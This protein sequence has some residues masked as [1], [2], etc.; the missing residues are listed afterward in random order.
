MMLPAEKNFKSGWLIR[1]EAE[2]DWEHGERPEQRTVEENLSNG[3]V[4]I[5][6]PAGV[7]SH[8]VSVDIKKFM[9]RSKAGHS[10]TLDPDVTGVLPVGIDNAT[11]VLQALKHAGKEYKGTMNLSEEF[12]R[13][14]IEEV[15]EDFIGTVKQTP[16]EI[17][18][19]K[20]EE[21]EREVYGIEIIKVEGGKVDFVIECERGFYVRV[22]C[23]QFGEKL[24]CDGELDSLRRTKVGLF[25][26]DQCVKPE[27]LREQFQLYSDGKDHRLDQYVRPVEAGVK[28][29][30]KVLLKDTAVSP[31]CH[32]ADLGTM[33][34]SKLQ[35][36]IE[37]GETV[38]LLT[39]KGELVAIG[40]ALMES[41]EMLEGKDTAVELQRVFLDKDVYPR[42][43]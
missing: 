28:H 15:A 11:K 20:R 39:L 18:A 24:G 4:L 36:D 37:K 33:G 16:P 13:E 9:K 7:K 5:D 32:G 6:K 17:S 14:K 38:A 30:K 1:E 23:R 10:G 8:E 27:E 26:D 3:L 21:R 2:T 25:E 31:V 35:E 40:E 12:S 29:L 43:W 19:V 41:E 34:I 42:K 22:F